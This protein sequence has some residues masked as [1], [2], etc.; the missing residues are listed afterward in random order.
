[1]LVFTTHNII[2]DPPFINLD[3]LCC[4][5]LLIYFEKDLQKK[6]LPAFHYSL[7]PD[8]LLFLG[9]SENIAQFNEHFA[10][11]DSQW[12]IFRRKSTKQS[13]PSW[14]RA[15]SSGLDGVIP[16]AG[17][18]KTSRKTTKK[19]TR[20]ASDQTARL[21]QE[22]QCTREQLLATIEELQSANEELESANE[23]MA[24]SKEELQSLNEEALTV[25]VELQN[26]VEE[27]RKANDDLKN[28]FDSTRIATIFLDKEFRVRFF[29]PP[30]T[31]IIPLT[32]TDIGRPLSHFSHSLLDVDL[33]A[34]A[35]LAL[36]DKEPHSKEVSSRDGL[37]F[38]MG[39]HLYRTTGGAINGVVLTFL[40]I[41]ERKRAEEET[42]RAREQW[43]RTFAGLGDLATIQDVDMRIV[44]AN[45]AACQTFDST[46]ENLRGRHC[47]ELFRGL[48]EPCPDCPI[49]A[50]LQ[51]MDVHRAEIEHVNLGK[52][53]LVTA[54]PIFDEQGKITHIAHIARDITDQKRMESQL[55]QAQKMEAIGALAGGIAHDFNNILMPIFG[56]ADL[57]RNALP[58]DSP[59]LE[60]IAAVI[61][62]GNRARELVQQILSFSRQT[63]R[64][65]VPTR[66]HIVVK[67]VLRLLRSSLPSTIDIQPDISPESGMAL[68]DPIQI[69]QILMNLGLNAAYAMRGK[70]GILRISLADAKIGLGDFRKTEGM[71]PGAYLHLQVS[72][73]GCGMDESTLER[74]FEPYFTTK[75][76]GEGTGFGLAVVHGIVTSHEGHIEVSSEPGV[77]TIFDIF[78]PRLP[79]D[80]ESA[81]KAPKGQT[82]PT[83]SER[84][85]VVD[86]DEEIVRMLQHLLTVLGYRVTHF[87]SSPQALQAFRKNPGEFDLVITDLTMPGLT[88][89]ELT[90][91]LLAV[92]P[93]L[94]IILC[95]GYH[96]EISREQAL[97]LGIR[98]LVIKPF[99]MEEIATTVRKVLE[100]RKPPTGVPLPPATRKGRKN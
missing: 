43:E 86:D 99:T 46:E 52:T 36:R 98:D 88:G 37:F 42:S 58:T 65:R 68:A 64:K 21:K 71:K 6:L 18:E 85:L 8:G 3:L 29:T 16:L 30:T 66:L 82:I 12:K 62:A 34:E 97:A 70:G 13:F 76:E 81:T 93:G 67:E 74:I 96:A 39:T 51:D 41:T 100:N 45:Q 32:P 25:N 40:D 19:K 49:T 23:E 44:R 60:D 87:V 55:R 63:E 91:K 31:A 57:I 11:L 2:K 92:R 14:P 26:R 50:S 75:P 83:G 90:R 17:A 27:L 80:H 22:L 95:T 59:L 94:P 79:S 20:Q 72:D 89:K 28:L 1:M 53:F 38:L 10:L 48:A 33:A 15:T 7:K 77:G 54:S 24:T 84:I 35:T 4:R 78:L 69:H 56:Y 9:T 47:Y 5:N 73:T 61:S